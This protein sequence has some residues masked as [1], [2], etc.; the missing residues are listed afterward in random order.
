MQT[1]NVQINIDS[2]TGHTAT[3]RLHRVVTVNKNY[4]LPHEKF[5]RQH[6]VIRNINFFLEFSNT[7][8]YA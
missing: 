3:V 1:I 5:V 7:N 4:N 8:F 2:P 6:G